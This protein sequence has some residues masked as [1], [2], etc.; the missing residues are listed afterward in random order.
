MS[1]IRI[2]FN[3]VGE[4]DLFVDGTGLPSSLGCRLQSCCCPSVTL[5]YMVLVPFA[6]KWIL[7][8]FITELLELRS[9]TME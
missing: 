8:S 4:R 5:P 3:L 7:P 1:I 6:F 2:D 9:W